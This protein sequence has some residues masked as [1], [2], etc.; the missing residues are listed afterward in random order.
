MQPHA[1]AQAWW[2]KAKTKMSSFFEK[3]LNLPEGVYLRRQ[4]MNQQFEVLGPL[5]SIALFTSPASSERSS[6]RSSKAIWVRTGYA[7]AKCMHGGAS[8]DART[9]KLKVGVFIPTTCPKRTR[10][11]KFAY[12]NTLVSLLQSAILGVSQGYVELLELHGLG[13]RVQNSHTATGSGAL[14]LKVGKTHE[15]TFQAHIQG[16]DRLRASAKLLPSKAQTS[17]WI[18]GVNK[19]K[20]SQ[21]GA[22]IQ[23]ISKADAYK[24]KG[25]HRKPYYQKAWK[26]FRLKEGKRH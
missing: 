2:R 15:S 22:S 25:I 4:G 20:V 1:A 11:R 21:L 23:H 26:T 10:K 3:T 24:G 18:Y 6:E 17:I 19:S 9:D 7:S 14:K 13:Y 5:G 12:L 16:C 8:A